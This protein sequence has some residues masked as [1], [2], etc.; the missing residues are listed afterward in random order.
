MDREL[1]EL[2]FK[3]L[4]TETCAYIFEQDNDFIVTVYIQYSVHVQK[5]WDHLGMT[6]VWR[7]EG[8]KKAHLKPGL[9]AQKRRPR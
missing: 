3:R 5:R 7:V 2:G 1:Q 8:G 9:G 6:G 4:T